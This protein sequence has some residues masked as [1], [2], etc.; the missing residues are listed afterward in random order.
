MIAER[1]VWI[2]E[3]HGAPVGFVSTMVLGE[4]VHVLELAVRA[5]H[6]RRGLGRMLMLAAV[7]A[8]R[9]RGHAAVTLTTFRSVVFNAPFY[10][11]LGFEELAAPP[12]YLA[13]ILGSE[14]ER[15]LADRCA[16]RLA[17]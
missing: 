10:R 17:L 7:G 12:P 5:D 8:A 16:M 4:G 2:A 3:E 11:T 9:A 15:R 1:A 14:A 13:A 6:Q